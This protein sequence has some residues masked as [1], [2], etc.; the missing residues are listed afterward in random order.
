MKKR[1]YPEDDTVVF[2]CDPK[3]NEVRFCWCLPHWS[4]MDNMLN[5][6]MLFDKEMIGQIKAWKNVD[7]YHFGFAK[8]EIGN[9]IANPK[10]QDK[11]LVN[12]VQ[13]SK[14]IIPH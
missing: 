1:P 14:V 6:E 8:D 10:Y 13:K 2:W 5:N 12:R 4:E 3:S 9:W 11:K 7:L